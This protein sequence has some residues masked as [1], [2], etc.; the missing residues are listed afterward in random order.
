MNE[1]LFRNHSVKCLVENGMPIISGQISTRVYPKSYIIS[2]PETL[3][4]GGHV[5]IKTEGNRFCSLQILAVGSLL[6]VIWQV[7]L[8]SQLGNGYLYSSVDWDVPCLQDHM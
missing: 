8:R 5:A 6:R 4:Q 1:F 3:S 2:D 7:L